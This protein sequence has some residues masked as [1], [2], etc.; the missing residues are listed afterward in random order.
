MKHFILTA[1]LLFFSNAALAL[2]LNECTPVIKA[3]GATRISCLTEKMYYV[4]DIEILMSPNTPQ[5]QGDNRIEH[6]TASLEIKRIDS[7][8][9][10]Y[11]I[12]STLVSTATIFDGSFEYDISSTGSAQFNSDALGLNLRD[13]IAPTN[14][15]VSISN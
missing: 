2:S 4:I 7:P 3:K 8:A 13:C 11:P 5:C 15:G 12:K 10:V 14:G 9:G 1:I 6:K